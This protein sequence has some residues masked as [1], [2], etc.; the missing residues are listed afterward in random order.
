VGGGRDVNVGNTGMAR[1]VAKV[2]VVGE[3]VPDFR[4]TEEE[5]DRV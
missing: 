5:L 3:D 2:H 4:L 1:K